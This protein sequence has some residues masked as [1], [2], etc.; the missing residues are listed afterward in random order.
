MSLTKPSKNSEYDDEREPRR[1]RGRRD[2]D[3]PKQP[4]DDEFIERVRVSDPEAYELDDV[5]IMEKLDDDD[6]HNMEG[7]D[8]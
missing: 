5:D 1:D 8:A 7:P 2:H 3:D 6:L 4:D